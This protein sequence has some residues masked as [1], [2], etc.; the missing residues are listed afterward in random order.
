MSASVPAKTV[1]AVHGVG[2]QTIYETVKKVLVRFARYH[3]VQI[4]ATQEDRKAAVPLGFFHTEDG[5]HSETFSYNSARSNQVT[6]NINFAEAYWANVPRRMIDEGFLVEDAKLWGQTVVGRINA[7]SKSRERM[8]EVLKEA[9]DTLKVLE[10]L[11][12]LADRMGIFKFD[13][14]RLIEDTLDDVQVVG[15]FVDERKQIVDAFERQVRQAYLHDPTAEIYIVAHSEGTVVSLLGMLRAACEPEEVIKVGNDEEDQ[16]EVKR[17]DW[18]NRVRGYMTIGSPIDKHIALWGHIFEDYRQPSLLAAKIEWRNYYDFGDPIGFELDEARERVNGKDASEW[19]WGNVFNFT[20]KDDYGF[21]RYPLAGAAHNEY[22]NDEDVF[23]HFIETVVY[24]DDK[25]VPPKYDKAPPNKWKWWPV[26]NFLPYLLDFALLFCAVLALYKGLNKYLA[27]GKM[28][29]AAV[30]VVGW[31]VLSLTCLLAGLTFMARIVRLTNPGLWWVFGVVFYALMWKAYYLCLPPGQPFS[32]N[33]S[34]NLPYLGHTL[35]FAYL[36][37]A[38][39]VF[40]ALA[41]W[42]FPRW[43]M[44]TLLIPGGIAVLSIV[45]YYLRRDEGGHGALWS[46]FLALAFFLYLWWLVAMVFDL[47]F[48]W[49]RYIRNSRY[50]PKVTPTQSWQRKVQTGEYQ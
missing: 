24:A 34:F 16:T 41:N 1:I 45:I 7:D 18:L 48:I 49:H 50:N 5:V 21:I 3:N 13:L 23:G 46:L 38:V 43:G 10:K 37:A 4:R 27:P 11:F 2:N 32:L 14:N 19:G 29:E 42:L 33:L 17:S 20:G 15:D 31:E 12:F 22:W 39:F 35:D 8:R 30:S 9:L 28:E 25:P 36:A 40:A 44:R 47:V 6:T 26:S